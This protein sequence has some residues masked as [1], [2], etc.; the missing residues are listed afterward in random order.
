MEE[1]PLPKLK[2]AVTLCNHVHTLD[3]IAVDLNFFP[4]KLVFP[5]LSENVYPLWPGMFVRPLGGVAIPDNLDE[6]NSFFEEMEFLLMQGKLVHF[7]PEGE[8]KHYDTSLRDFKKGAFHLAA[9]ARVPIV[10]MSIS[11]KEP[12]GFQRLYRRKPTM[13]LNIGEVIYP[14]EADWKKDMEIRQEKS[15]KQMEAMLPRQGYEKKKLLN[16][17]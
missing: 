17:R 2:G 10:P 14:L 5:T 11:F 6:L 1:K 12:D 16:L 13:V 4:R 8:L 15:R 3:C 7:F 9:Q